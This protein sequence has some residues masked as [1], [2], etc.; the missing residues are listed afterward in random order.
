M[1]QNLAPVGTVAG[2]ALLPNTG[3][4]IVLLVASTATIAV[5]VAVMVTTAMRHSAKKAYRA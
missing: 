5:G 1:Y 3:G 2:I 4:D